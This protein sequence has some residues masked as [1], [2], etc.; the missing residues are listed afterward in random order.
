MVQNYN[1]LEKGKISLAI[2]SS[3]STKC[4]KY[5]ESN[6]GINSI[7]HIKILLDMRI[8]EKLKNTATT[9]STIL[10]FFRRDLEKYSTR[11]RKVE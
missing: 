5:E 9:F 4:K 7:P 8:I 1:D 6:V 11:K 2:D 3:F 10:I